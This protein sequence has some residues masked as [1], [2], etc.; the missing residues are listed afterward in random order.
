MLLIAAGLADSQVISAILEMY[1]G[2]T[3]C[4]ALGMLLLI[5]WFKKV[6]FWLCSL[7]RDVKEQL[8]KKLIVLYVFVNCRRSRAMVELRI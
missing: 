3:S 2:M 8:V 5:C 6:V 4:T 1:A 7:I